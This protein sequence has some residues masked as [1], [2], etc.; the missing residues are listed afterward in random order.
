MTSRER[1]LTALDHRRP[2]RIPVDFG[3]TA[4][5]GM[6]VTVVAD[7]RRHYGLEDRPVKVWEPYQM[8]GALDEDLMETLSIDVEGIGGRNTLFGFPNENWRDFITPWGQKV[9]VS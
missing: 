1:V 8:L 7:L 3:S 4:V 6:H 2:D 9:L 5:T